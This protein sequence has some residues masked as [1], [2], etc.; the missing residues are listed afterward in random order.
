MSA[1]ANLFRS[2][3]PAVAAYLAVAASGKI[4]ELNT[5]PASGLDLAY[6]NQLF[7]QQQAAVV[8]QQQQQDLQRQLLA[9]LALNNSARNGSSLSPVAAVA[10][11]SI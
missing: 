1:A 3:N 5:S 8:Q 11:N 6:Y 7:L 2:A 10:S 9:Y 4:P